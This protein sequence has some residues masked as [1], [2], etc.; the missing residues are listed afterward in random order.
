MTLRQRMRRLDDNPVSGGIAWIGT[1]ISAPVA[2]V[3]GLVLLIIGLIEA[4]I[5][6]ADVVPL[7]IFGAFW[8]VIGLVLLP[9]RLRRRLGLRR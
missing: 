1:N 2:V 6:G 7:L 9:P 8:L 4:A 5:G 3:G